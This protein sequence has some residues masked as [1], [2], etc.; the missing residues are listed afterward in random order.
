MASE[1]TKYTPLELT[2]TIVSVI[3]AI[4]SIAVAFIPEMFLFVV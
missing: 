2:L 1:P 3:V 4:V